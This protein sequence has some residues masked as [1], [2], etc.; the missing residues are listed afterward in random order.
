LRP[1]N[2]PFK[3]Q[4]LSTASCSGS[5]SSLDTVTGPIK[6]RMSV[7][8]LSIPALVNGEN[9]DLVVARQDNITRGSAH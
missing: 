9:F 7:L 4:T 6:M 8:R 5:R 3:T 2:K 1:L